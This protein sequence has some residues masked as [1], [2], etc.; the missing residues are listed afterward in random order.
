M[1]LADCFVGAS[2]VSLGV[3]LHLKKPNKVYMLYGILPLFANMFT[4]IFLL[5][6]LTVDRWIAVKF[7]FRYKRIMHMRR[8]KILIGISWALSLLIYTQ[9][10]LVFLYVSKRIELRLRGFILST[11]FIIGSTLLLV[12]NTSLLFIIK[13]HL[14]FLKTNSSYT[15][16]KQSMELNELYKA[17]SAAQKSETNLKD[18][19]EESSLASKT[20]DNSSKKGFFKEIKAA[21]MCIIITLVFII[22]GLPL[23]SYRLSYSLGYAVRI[24]WLRR[25]CLLLASANSL[26]N[27]FIYL[28]L[29]KSFR[30]YI[31]KISIVKF[32]TG[33]Y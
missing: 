26:L 9:E 8:I 5:G 33:K 28:V 27:P 16:S 24:K 3:L 17:S 14:R 19:V 32:F 10:A 6:I 29:I 4:S 11:F 1:A 13:K 20:Q 15:H 7:P 21:K 18:P 30:S 23:A 12:S 2:L 31:R 25:S 22:C